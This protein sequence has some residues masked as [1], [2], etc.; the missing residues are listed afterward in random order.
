MNWVPITSPHFEIRNIKKTIQDS[1]VHLSWHWPKEIDFVYIYQT[2]ADEVKPIS[3]LRENDVKLYTRDEYKGNLGYVSKLDTIGRTA[4][5]IFPCQKREGGLIVFSQQNENNLVY[6]NG[7]RAKIYFSIAY[8]QKLFQIRKKVR[9]T[10]DTE[11]PIDKE[12]LVYVKKSG[13][14]PGSP[15]DGTVYPFV[16]GFSAGKTVLPEIEIE[17][18]EFLAIFFN[19]GK[20]LAQ[21][22][23]LIPQ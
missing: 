17:K 16:R 6:I 21:K 7:L 20:N 15:E 11:L 23:E 3:E 14:L 4:C 8:K 2:S 12:L 10:I 22:Y 19:N 9:M 1:E 5:Q 13:G 18:N